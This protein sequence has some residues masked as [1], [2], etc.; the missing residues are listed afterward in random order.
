MRMG[1]TLRV[2]NGHARA[3]SDGRTAA[4]CNVL[5]PDARSSAECGLPRL[6]LLKNRFGLVCGRLTPEFMKN[7]SF[8]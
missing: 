8:S 4:A 5:C 3:V 1:L 7:L 2:T 6:Q